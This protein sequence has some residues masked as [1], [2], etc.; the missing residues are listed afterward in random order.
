M[1]KFIVVSIQGTGR[2]NGI[3]VIAYDNIYDELTGK[4]ALRLCKGQSNVEEV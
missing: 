1:G 3:D 4:N 2:V